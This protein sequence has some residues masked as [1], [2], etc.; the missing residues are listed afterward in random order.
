[1]CPLLSARF[2]CYTCI[3]R[4][5]PA[6]CSVRLL[7]AALSLPVGV[8]AFAVLCGGGS[9]R[10]VVPLSCGLCG[11]RCNIALL[12]S[13]RPDPVRVSL[14]VADRCRVRRSSRPPDRSRL[15]LSC[16]PSPLSSAYFGR[17]RQ[18]KG[19]GC[20]LPLLFWLL[21]ILPGSRQRV[22]DRRQRCCVLP[23]PVPAPASV[24]DR[25]KGCRYA[26]RVG[27]VPACKRVPCRS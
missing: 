27:S 22:P 1:M 21:L 16:R 18:Q 24:H 25:F 3:V 7:A 19:K 20:R 6:S 14:L 15:L 5:A 11:Q 2:V 17:N 12:T 9:R 4:A 26:V 10:A 8:A 13:R 23:D